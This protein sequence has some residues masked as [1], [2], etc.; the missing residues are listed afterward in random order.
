MIKTADTVYI[1]YLSFGLDN[2]PN[3]PENQTKLETLWKKYE[4]IVK[5]L[6]LPPREKIYE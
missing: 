4:S 2:N 5:Q 1:Q 3:L 6:G